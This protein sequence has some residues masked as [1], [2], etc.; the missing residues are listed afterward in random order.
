VT[1]LMDR[2]A[3]ARLA[4]FAVTAVLAA[5]GEDG[6]DR[7]DRAPTVVGGIV[8]SAV[9]VDRIEGV[10]TAYANEATV[11]TSPVTER[12]VSVR[13]ADGE[14]VARGEVIAILSASEEKADLASASARTREAEQQLSRLRELQARGFATNAR[15]DEQIAARNAARAEAGAIRAQIGDRVIR[16]PF[17]GVVGLRRISPGAVVSA[18][19]PIATVSDI[20]RIKLDFTVPERFLSA[21]AIGGSIE[22]HTPAYPGET[23][24]GRIA[25]IDPQIDPLTR[26]VTLRAILSN[27]DGRL[28]PGMLLTTDIVSNRREAL[29]VPELALVAQRDQNFVFRLDDKNIANRVAVA[30]GARQDGMVEVTSGLR[31]GD[32][33][34]ADGIVKVRD[35]GEVK[36]LFPGDAPAGRPSPAGGRMSAR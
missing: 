34:V 26:S 11:L 5:C 18:G 6:A 13:F 7:R 35:D 22:A 28:R 30:T 23:F 8:G 20:S 31:R 24:V 15:V 10:G 1:L 19:T 27:A 29:A 17:S 9:F 4:V 2:R 14:R 36:P 25:G 16:A 32:R 33:I 12:I 21:V 3:I